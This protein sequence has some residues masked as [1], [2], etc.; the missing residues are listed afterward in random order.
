[1]SEKKLFTNKLVVQIYRQ[2]LRCGRIQRGGAA[3]NRL[4]HLTQF[5]KGRMKKYD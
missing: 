3:Q 5:P 1:M 2:L 4:M